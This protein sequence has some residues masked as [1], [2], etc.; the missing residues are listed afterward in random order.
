MNSLT[1][2][3]SEICEFIDHC[4]QSQGMSPTLQEIADRF[5]FAGP[6]GVRDHVRAL[7]KKGAI[8]R[9]RGKARSLRVLPGVLSPGRDEGIPLVGRIAAG[10]PIDAVE[11]CEGF[12]PIPN[13]LFPGGDLFALAVRG[14][15]M[16]NE[17]IR[18]GDIAVIRRQDDVGDGE[19]A[20][21]VLGE[22]ATLKKVFRRR[23]RLVLRAANP[24][25]DDIVVDSSSPEPI[26]IAG[27]Y[28]GLF[29][30]LSPNSTGIV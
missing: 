27:R 1:D 28:V 22:E 26:R 29:R 9:E 15:S 17:G 11:N 24:A 20:A 5:G 30:S 19:I 10:A 21:V 6:T 18:D 8:R 2:R 14:D 7:E 3:Q 25:F 13:R 16:T 4:S 12:L 23:S